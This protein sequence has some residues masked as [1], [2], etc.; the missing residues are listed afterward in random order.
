MKIE[1]INEKKD[2][3]KITLRCPGCGDTAVF[4]PV[5]SDT[6]IT[7]F[8]QVGS[9]VC[10]SCNE[11]VF[12]VIDRTDSSVICTYPPCLIDFNADH[13]PESVS[14]LFKEALKCNANECFVASAIMVRRT[15]EEICAECGAKGSSLKKRIA[16]L[17]NKIVLPADLLKAFDELRILG[18]DAAHVEAKE[19][20]NISEDELKLAIECTKEIMKGLYQYADLLKR[21]RGLKS[22]S[23]E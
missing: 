3:P 4:D 6:S 12:A 22:T 20:M 17:Q 14:A 15:L 10:P 18:N 16:D 23:T 8:Q 1:Q 19:Y 9:R 2:G 11:H 7:S 5:G 13:I 21:L